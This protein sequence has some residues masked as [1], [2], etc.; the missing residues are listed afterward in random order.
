MNLHM[1]S[2]NA[3][4]PPQHLSG[5]DVRGVVE[6]GLHGDAPWALSALPDCFSQEDEWKGPATYVDAHIPGLARAVAPGATLRY[7]PCTISVGSGELMVSRGPDRFRVPPHA[8]LYRDGDA[9][10]LLRTASG[11]AVLRR[12]TPSSLP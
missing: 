3:S 7:G 6:R 9:L 12:Y 1:R 8:V 4:P 11:H 2:S 5:G 10:L